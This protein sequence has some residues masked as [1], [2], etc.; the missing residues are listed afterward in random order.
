MRLAARALILAIGAYQRLL[1]PVLPRACRFVP[2][3]SEYA[4]QAIGTHGPARGTWLALGRL[5]RCHPFHQG[6]VDPPP[7][8]RTGGKA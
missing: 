8:A 1:S 4:R 3:C 5:L 2:T 6:G 7:S